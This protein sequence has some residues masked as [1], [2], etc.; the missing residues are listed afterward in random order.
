MNPGKMNE[1]TTD[2]KEMKGPFLSDIPLVQA[3]L[4]M[5]GF[6]GDS[7]TIQPMFWEKHPDLR[8]LD[9]ERLLH[10][11]AIYPAASSNLRLATQKGCFTVHGSKGLPIESIFKD[12][13]CERFLKKIIIK[14][15]AAVQIREELRIMG[16]TPRSVFPDLGGLSQELSGREY[17]IGL[18]R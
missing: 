10:P 17:M 15:G 18:Q 8:S 13:N 12:A 4:K 1:F 7:E 16:I 6:L 9:K 14:T 5:V 2:G 11:V 3:R